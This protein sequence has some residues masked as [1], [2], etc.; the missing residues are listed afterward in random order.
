[1][2]VLPYATSGNTTGSIRRRWRTSYST[3]PEC[4]SL[5]M[6]DTRL[7]LERVRMS[8]HEVPVPGTPVWHTTSRCTGICTVVAHLSLQSKKLIHS[9]LF[10]L[11]AHQAHLANPAQHPASASRLLEPV[12]AIKYK[13]NSTRTQV[14][15]QSTCCARSFS[16]ALSL[17]SQFR[18]SCLHLT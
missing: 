10:P 16:Y 9:D 7:Q 18:P 13:Y 14:P 6:Y 8:R 17:L 11:I 12:P 5:S 1:M 15:V 3:S 4:S 2:T